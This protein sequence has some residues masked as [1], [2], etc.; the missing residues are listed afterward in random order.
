[1]RQ[2]R[3]ARAR[4]SHNVE[5][6]QVEKER[7]SPRASHG[8]RVPVQDKYRNG[9]AGSRER[10][11]GSPQRGVGGEW[12]GGQQSKKAGDALSTLRQFLAASAL[13]SVTDRRGE[14]KQ[15]RDEPSGRAKSARFE[16][17]GS[18]GGKRAKS[19]QRHGGTES[20]GS[21]DSL[22]EDARSR[23]GKNTLGGARR[24]SR[25]RR[26]EAS[27]RRG[28]SSSNEGDSLDSARQ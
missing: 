7:R 18:T 11:G 12:G 8:G 26:A 19:M 24:A 16:D 9:H 2:S 10:R 14:S 27:M 6:K 23:G 22:E 17:K 21:D 15:G 4:G 5:V 28:R 3:R 20:G 1:M 25:G 13:E